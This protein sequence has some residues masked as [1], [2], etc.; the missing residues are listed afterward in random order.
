[1][2]KNFLS[3]TILLVAAWNSTVSGQNNKGY[4]IYFSEYSLE[5]NLVLRINNSNRDLE[6][7]FW[8]KN[9]LRIENSLPDSLNNVLTESNW[10]EMMGIKVNKFPSRTDVTILGGKFPITQAYKDRGNFN[11]LGTVQQMMVAQD[12]IEPQ[13]SQVLNT[14]KGLQ[15][16]G[17]NT[18]TV[19]YIP[20][21]SS[22][23][24]VNKYSSVSISGNIT[25]GYLN[26]ENTVLDAA[27]FGSLR[28][29]A[30]YSTV[31][32]AASGDCEADIANSSFRAGTIDKAE[33]ESTR[34]TV[35]LEKGNIVYIRSN[36]DN[37]YTIEEV[38]TIE[39]RLLYSNI[40]IE[41]LNRKMDFEGNNYDVKLREIAT[42]AE[43]IKVNNSFADLRLPV[44][45]LA[46]YSVSFDGKYS[47]VFAPF[48]IVPAKRDDT[49]KTVGSLALGA[50]PY[51]NTFQTP[52]APRFFTATAGNEQSK[53]TVFEL[54]CHRCTVDF[55]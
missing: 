32:I 8:E 5:K 17:V 30:K 35:D 29:I 54:V 42:S 12:A 46:G 51:T 55:K 16:L 23:D 31:N 38:T 15:V 20:A 7:K 13:T 2:K 48:E 22:V 28:L 49:E 21:S 3:L 18:T 24:L 45:G 52:N 41:K 27:S 44:K 53:K 6:I 34:S 36:L 4:K 43:L 33:I 26:L 14:N 11:S 37:G 40:R 39:G 25:K 47:S 10:Q 50:T 19:I 9:I 1:M